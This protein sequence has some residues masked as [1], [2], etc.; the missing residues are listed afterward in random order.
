MT[1]NS[2]IP[3]WVRGSLALVRTTRLCSI[4]SKSKL[5]QAIQMVK[6]KS[7]IITTNAYHPWNAALRHLMQTSNGKYAD[8]GLQQMA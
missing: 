8:R 5:I 6:T 7:N 1:I 4:E 2:G 3:S